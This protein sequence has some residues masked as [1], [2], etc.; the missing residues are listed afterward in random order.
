[1]SP[2]RRMQVGREP[3]LAVLPF[4]NLTGRTD[5]DYLMDGIVADL[6]SALNRVSGKRSMIRQI[7]VSNI[8]SYNISFFIKAAQGLGP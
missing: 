7:S 1:M 4:A 3:S 6:A 2:V 5:Q 8:V